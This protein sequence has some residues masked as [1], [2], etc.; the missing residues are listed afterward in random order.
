MLIYKLASRK[1]SGNSY[2]CAVGANSADTAHLLANDATGS[3]NTKQLA[4]ALATPLNTQLAKTIEKL[5][6]GCLASRN[7]T[8][9][10]QYWLRS[11]RH[12]LPRIWQ[13]MLLRPITCR[14]GLQ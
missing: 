1:S 13:K 2:K 3:A 7:G 11:Q 6:M 14:S 4:R 9:G 12:E 5:T 10:A 8:S